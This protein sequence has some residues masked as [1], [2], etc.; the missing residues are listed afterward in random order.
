MLEALDK[1]NADH[2]QDF[3]NYERYSKLAT[4]RDNGEEIDEAGHELLS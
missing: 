1:F 3:E 4:A 2:Q